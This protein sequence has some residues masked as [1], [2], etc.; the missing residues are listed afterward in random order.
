M[1][2]RTKAR[3]QPIAEA[4]ENAYH[5]APVL[6]GGAA[7]GVSGPSQ[8]ALLF[9]LTAEQAKQQAD[10]EEQVIF[11]LPPCSCKA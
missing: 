11:V 4:E 3:Q 9:G 7:P 1:I 2:K 5:K 6:V 8:A 10:D